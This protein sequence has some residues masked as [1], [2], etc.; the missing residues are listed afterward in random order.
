MIAKNKHYHAGFVNSILFHG[1][2]AVYHSFIFHRL[3]G[4]NSL[5]Q[6]P[7]QPKQNRLSNHLAQ[8]RIFLVFFLL[9]SCLEHI[10]P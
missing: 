10:N 3:L 9:L 2:P 8:V 7:L 1:F 4:F 6:K 5:I